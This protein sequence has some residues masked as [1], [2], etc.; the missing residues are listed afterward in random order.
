MPRLDESMPFPAGFSCDVFY[1]W[2]LNVSS[3]FMISAAH[4][5]LYFVL[6]FRTPVFHFLHHVFTFGFLVITSLASHFPHCLPKPEALVAPVGLQCV[7]TLLTAIVHSSN[8]IGSLYLLRLT[9]VFSTL[10]VLKFLPLGSDKFP[11]WGLMIPLSIG[12]SLS[13]L[14]LG[15]L[16]YDLPGL[17]LSPI[18]GFLR[19]LQLIVMQKSY[20]QSG[21]TSCVQ[22]STFFTAAVSVVLFIPATISYSMTEV[23][24]DASWE[25]IDYTLIGLSFFFMICYKYSELFLTLNL[26]ARLVLAAEQ[27]KF[28]MASVG[29]WFLQNMAHATIFSFCG[30]MLF[31]SSLLRMISHCP[32]GSYGDVPKKV[33]QQ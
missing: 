30:K 3:S 8:R 27:T 18:L 31:V 15:N 28:F 24:A 12:A 20:R 23:K 7:V 4:N 1:Y 10:A 21:A 33:V 2:L 26:D 6:D 29:Q 13:W 16:E 19:G 32:F 11:R 14:E 25:S 22:F 9:D 5:T 17:L